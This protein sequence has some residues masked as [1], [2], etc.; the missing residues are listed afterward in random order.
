M[1]TSTPNILLSIV[2][3]LLLIS[4]I[5]SMMIARRIFFRVTQ[6]HFPISIIE[7]L[8]IPI[9]LL[10]WFLLVAFFYIPFYHLIWFFKDVI[11]PLFQQN[12]FH[13]PGRII[14]VWGEVP[15]SLHLAFMF[16]FLAVVY[17]FPLLMGI[18]ASQKLANSTSPLNKMDFIFI[19]LGV[20]GVLFEGFSKF[21]ISIA[22]RQTPIAIISQVNHPVY[23]IVSWFLAILIIGLLS[24]L[25]LQKQ[26]AK[27]N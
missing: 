7:R 16:G 4:I 11:L 19:S 26:L 8:N 6:S 14:T 13:H 10:I 12:Q 9:Y 27:L 18:K 21:I 24:L 5:P 25:L 23:F 20:G 2:E 3:Y 17:L 1:I 15:Y 22:W